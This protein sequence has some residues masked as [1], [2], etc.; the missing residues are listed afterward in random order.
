MK[1]VAIDFETSGY[2]GNSACA[3]GIAVI[4][5]GRIV[6]H[7]YSLI[8]PPSRN[9]LFTEIHGLTW[10]MLKDAGSFAEV[11]PEFA[12]FMAGADYFLAHNATFD[13]RVLL[14]SCRA[15]GIREPQTP[16]LCT[17][18]GCRIKLDIPSKKLSAVCEHFCIDLDH[19]HAGSD[20]NACAEVFLEL[21]RLGLKPEQMKI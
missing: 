12:P 4:E 3:L 14:E 10:E 6:D 13:R 2:G 17:L 20:A 8:C 7:H 1:L 21:L 9:I 15:V 16:F 19:H 18:K 11:W 5:D